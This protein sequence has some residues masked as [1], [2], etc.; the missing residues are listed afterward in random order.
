M[1]AISPFSC[2]VSSDFSILM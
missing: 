2:I 1:G